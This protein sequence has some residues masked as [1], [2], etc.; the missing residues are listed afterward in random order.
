[1]SRRGRATRDGPDGGLVVDKPA[2]IT[3]HDVV[4]VARRAFG[5]PR[6]GHTGTLDPIATGVLVLLLGRA[7]RLAQ[8]LAA[9]QK[10]YR[11]Q[12]RFGFATKTYDAEGEPAGA[13]RQSV[14]GDAGHPALTIDSATL[15]RALDQFR[16]R[17]LQTPPPVSA[18]RVGGRRAYDLA[19][20]DQPVTLAPVT[21]EVFDLRLLE[22]D[23]DT[24]TL[25]VTCS[26]GFYVRALA[27]ALGEQLGH[28]AH[29]VALRRERAGHLGLADAVPLRTVAEAPDTALP[30]MISMASLLPDLP[31]ATLNEQGRLRVKH[32]Q[33]VRP[34]DVATTSAG[35][36]QSAERVRLVDGEGTLVGLA[37]PGS[38]A[39]HPVVVLM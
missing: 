4:A 25:T 38:A 21:V 34:D 37:E 29:L 35:W 32:G 14:P 27:H 5:Q 23:G 11:A 19:R 1:M 15:A 30:R 13:G 26:A 33:L 12:V 36:P 22:L 17:H 20:A 28:G 18:K 8:F 24:A 10:T 16:G 2:G 7:T 39:L 31:V 6:I 3:S 9:G